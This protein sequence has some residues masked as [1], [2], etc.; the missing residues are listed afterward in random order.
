VYEITTDFPVTMFG[1]T[2]TLKLKANYESCPSEDNEGECHAIEGGDAAITLNE[3]NSSASNITNGTNGTNATECKPMQDR[4]SAYGSTD[5]TFKDVFGLQG[6][7]MGLRSINVTGHDLTLEGKAMYA[8]LE[9]EAMA[10]V[11]MTWTPE[12]KYCS[13]LQVETSPAAMVEVAA[14]ILG[15][16]DLP[17]PNDVNPVSQ[18]SGMSNRTFRIK[19]CSL[20]AWRKWGQWFRESASEPLWKALTAIGAD[21]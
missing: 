15:F 7:N 9:T 1:E 8:K 11:Y 17:I 3:S 21:Y 2:G 18:A 10:R 6:L 16:E 12:L 5:L 4:F 20:E 14:S 19:I 13:Q